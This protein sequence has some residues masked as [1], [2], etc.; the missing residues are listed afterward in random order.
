MKIQV[1]LQYLYFKER[2]FFQDTLEVS[3]VL[4]LQKD[5]YFSSYLQYRYY[6]LRI[7]Q[8][9]FDLFTKAIGP[10]SISYCCVVFMPV[11]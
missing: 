5:L 11:N 4:E 8:R 2:Q 6:K 1:R 7:V 3:Q 10:R 9:L